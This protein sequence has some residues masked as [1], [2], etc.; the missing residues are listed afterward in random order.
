M[1]TSFAPH[2]AAHVSL[3]WSKILNRIA[4]FFSV[5]ESAS[6]PPALPDALRRLSPHLLADIG[7]EPR[8]AVEDDFSQRGTS[9]GL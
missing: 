1:S 2:H 3:D 5:H 9:P 4:A 7:V 8:F 6:V